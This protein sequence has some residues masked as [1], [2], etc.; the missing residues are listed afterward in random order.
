[1]VY[2]EC[3]GVRGLD[4]GARRVRAGVRACTGGVERVHKCTDSAASSSDF[5]ICT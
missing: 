3:L 1:M 4:H 2:E 5:S